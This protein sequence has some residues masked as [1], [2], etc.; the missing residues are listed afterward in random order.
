MKWEEQAQQ[1]MKGSMGDSLRSVIDSECGRELAKNFN[2]KVVEQAVRDGDT[3]ALTALLKQVLESPEG[4]RFA[5]QIQR[6]VSDGR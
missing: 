2:G 3:K 5:E 4:K 6:T 1:L